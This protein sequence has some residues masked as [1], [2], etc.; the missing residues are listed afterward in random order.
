[1]HTQARD[2]LQSVNRGESEGDTGTTQARDGLQ[3]VNR[4][5]SEGDTGTTQAVCQ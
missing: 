3:S 4:G 1:M 5:E 2:G